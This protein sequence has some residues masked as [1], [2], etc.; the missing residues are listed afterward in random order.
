MN[1]TLMMEN[2]IIEYKNKRRGE[3]LL[4]KKILSNFI[5]SFLLIGITIV[6]LEQAD[7]SVNF[8]V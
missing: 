4:P 2:E 8:N 1:I 7:S 5:K 3:L 6:L